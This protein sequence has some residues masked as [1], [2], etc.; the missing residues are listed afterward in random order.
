MGTDVT[1][2]DPRFPDPSQYLG[3]LNIV[4]CGRDPKLTLRN[5]RGPIVELVLGS[6][7]WVCA[8]G[9][10]IWN[11]HFQGWVR[12]PRPL[13][14]DHCLRTCFPQGP[15]PLWTGWQQT[16]MAP[17]PWAPV[18]E[19]QPGKRGRDKLKVLSPFQSHADGTLSRSWS[20]NSPPCSG[21][22]MVAGPAH[23]GHL[24]VIKSNA[25]ETYL[26]RYVPPSSGPESA[27]GLHHKDRPGFTCWPNV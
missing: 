15:Q 19:E 4:Y 22:S 6:G 11:R 17:L 14:L 26:R 9:R 12:R 18:V 2:Q 5:V 23:V 16:P 7:T 24:R 10:A 20:R 27:A 13:S 21:H 25:E 3:V 8:H 1:S